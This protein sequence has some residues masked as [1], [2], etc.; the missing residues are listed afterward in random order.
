[1]PDQEFV[2]TAQRRKPKLNRRP[3]QLFCAQMPDI[4]PKIIP[5]QFR[6]PGRPIP[7]LP[8][9]ILKVG[10]RLSIIPLRINRC[11]AIGPEVLEELH[12]PFIFWRG[13]GSFAHCSRIRAP[14]ERINAAEKTS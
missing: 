2:K 13:R 11:P 4:G 8:M 5:L 10:Q 7:L 14:E 1:M 3:S 12:N 6:P 9:P